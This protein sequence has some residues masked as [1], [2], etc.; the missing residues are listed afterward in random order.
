MDKFDYIL[1]KREGIMPLKA[2]D[3]NRDIQHDR[4]ADIR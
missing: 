2:E 4:I 1:R 3:F